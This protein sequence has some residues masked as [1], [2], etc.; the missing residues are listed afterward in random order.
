MMPVVGVL[1]G[2]AAVV[3]VESLIGVVLD[4]AIVVHLPFILIP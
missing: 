2:F 1:V 4:S 3:L